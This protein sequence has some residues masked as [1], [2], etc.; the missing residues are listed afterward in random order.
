M[1][2][3]LVSDYHDLADIFENLSPDYII[4]HTGIRSD[5][6]VIN[7]IISFA[8]NEICV[9]RVIKSCYLRFG[10]HYIYVRDV[11]G[12]DRSVLDLQ[13]YSPLKD[14]LAFDIFSKIALPSDMTIL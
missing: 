5:S 14:D 7:N 11:V 9:D 4:L 2:A 12:E 3:L 6:S 13:S 1:V 10:D 8:R